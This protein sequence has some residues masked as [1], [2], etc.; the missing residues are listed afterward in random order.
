MIWSFYPL[1]IYVKNLWKVFIH[2]CTGTDLSKS[3]SNM[4]MIWLCSLTKSF[5][6]FGIFRILWTYEKVSACSFPTN[7]FIVNT[8]FI[9][10]DI[11][12]EAI[13]W[14]FIFFT[15]SIKK[16]FKSICYWLK[17]TLSLYLLLE[18]KP[19]LG[20]TGKD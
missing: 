15:S 17:D 14:A 2:P 13:V 20:C 9:Y 10:S 1:L 7:G 4:A 8:F 6:D 3:D 11:F 16:T 5:F 19:E 12:P 18:M